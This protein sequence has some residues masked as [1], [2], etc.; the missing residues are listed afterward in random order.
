SL[1]LQPFRKTVILIYR[2]YPPPSAC[3]S[4]CWLSS[5]HPDYSGL[6]ILYEVRNSA[7]AFQN[8]HNNALS[9]RRILHPAPRLPTLRQYDAPLSTLPASVRQALL[10]NGD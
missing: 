2:Q 5:A 9:S 8:Y 10:C 1:G 6:Q 3:Q 4:T 7:P